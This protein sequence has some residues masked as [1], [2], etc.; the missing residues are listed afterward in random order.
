MNN[1]TMRINCN[2]QMILNED[3]VISSWLSGSKIIAAIFEDESPINIYNE[4]CRHYDVNTLIE[5]QSED[6]SDNYPEKCLKNWNMP[7]SYRN[8]NI[9]DYLISL[10]TTQQEQ[11]RVIYELTLYEERGMLIVLQFLKYLADVC[12]ENKIVLGVGR[13]SSVA[14]YCLYLLGIHK[15]NSIKYDLDIKEFLK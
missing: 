2:K 8:L 9:V 5:T 4:W 12:Q 6:S 13:G 3:D 14:S 15:I 7:D 11:Q 10:T 1:Y